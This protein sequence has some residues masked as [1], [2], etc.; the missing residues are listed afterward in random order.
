MSKTSLAQQTRANKREEKK[1]KSK[2]TFLDNLEENFFLPTECMMSNSF[3]NAKSRQKVFWSNA[4]EVFCFTY[5]IR[6][7]ETSPD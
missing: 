6:Y 2:T 5:C 3:A 1:R 4:V 7:N